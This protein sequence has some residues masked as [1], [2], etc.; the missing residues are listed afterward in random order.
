MGWR[1]GTELINTKELRG[2][3]DFPLKG[4]SGG[5]VCVWGGGGGDWIFDHEGMGRG[6][7]W[8]FHHKRMKKGD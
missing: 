5:C 8:T 4:N 1:L 6:E 2:K 7:N 3:L